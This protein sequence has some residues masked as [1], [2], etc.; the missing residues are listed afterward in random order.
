MSDTKIFYDPWD[1]ASMYERA[2]VISSMH[3]VHHAFMAAA[4]GK[5]A[6]QRELKWWGVSIMESSYG[7]VSNFYLPSLRH[8]VR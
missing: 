8:V 5:M 6:R 1:V 7:P 4:H 2:R 3:D